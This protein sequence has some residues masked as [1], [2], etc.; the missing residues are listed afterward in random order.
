MGVVRTAARFPIGIVAADAH[1]G[2]ITTP[3]GGGGHNL[4]TPPAPDV[5]LLGVVGRTT[6]HRGFLS[7]LSAGFQTTRGRPFTVTYTSLHSGRVMTTPARDVGRRRDP[8]RHHVWR[9]SGRT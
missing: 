4:P 8:T 3:A 5:P 2:R 9:G 6:A 1:N 7:F